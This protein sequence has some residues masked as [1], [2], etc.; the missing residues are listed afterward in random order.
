MPKK[1]FF[2]D[3]H[4][5]SGFPSKKIMSIFGRFDF[6]SFKKKTLK[7]SDEARKTS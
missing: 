5:K 1:N 4:Q 2:W 6:P 3:L 7:G